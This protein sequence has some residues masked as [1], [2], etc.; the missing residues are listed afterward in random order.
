MFTS[1][2]RI[3]IVV[4]FL[5]GFAAGQ[6]IAAETPGTGVIALKAARLF[7]GKAKALVANGVVVIEGDKIVDAGRLR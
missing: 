6:A 1:L 3:Q 5:A 2:V 4:L 7:D